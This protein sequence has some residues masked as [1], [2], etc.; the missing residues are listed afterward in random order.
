MEGDIPRQLLEVVGTGHKVGFAVE[1]DKRANLAVM[2]EVTHHD[3][4]GGHPA[5]TLFRFRNALLSQ[6]LGSFFHVAGGLLQRSLAV[7]H[8]GASADPEVTYIFWGNRRARHSLQ[9]GST[10]G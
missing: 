1:L 5:G 6:E 4:L 8:A 9:L 10:Q 2:M 7:H 3:T